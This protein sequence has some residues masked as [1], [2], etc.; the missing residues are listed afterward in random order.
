MLLFRCRA[1]DI[2]DMMR[3]AATTLYRHFMHGGACCQIAADIDVITLFRHLRQL[4]MT[5]T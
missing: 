3:R 4:L 1:R 5:P 2:A